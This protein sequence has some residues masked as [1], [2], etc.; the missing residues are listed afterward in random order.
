MAD[1]ANDDPNAQLHEHC[2]VSR[3]A[4]DK[5]MIS[6]E[7][8]STQKDL[9]T[10]EL[11]IMIEKSL[12]DIL[13]K[14]VHN[15]QSINPSVLYNVVDQVGLELL[16]KSSSEIQLDAHIAKFFD[17]RADADRMS[18]SLYTSSTFMT[19]TVIFVRRKTDTA[20]EQNQYRNV[21]AI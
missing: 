20:I 21:L 7:V 1:E 4:N 11:S 17:T 15:A 3:S 12:H 2:M 10:K 16:C 9:V 5:N 18:K 6:R 13:P 8:I 19:T 14:L